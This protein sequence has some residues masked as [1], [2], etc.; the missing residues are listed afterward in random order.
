MNEISRF[1]ASLAHHAKQAGARTFP[2]MSTL[3]RVVFSTTGYSRISDVRLEGSDTFPG[4]EGVGHEEYNFVIP[5]LTGKRLALCA[6]G[7]DQCNGHNLYTWSYQPD[8]QKIVVGMFTNISPFSGE[9]HE[10]K[11]NLLINNRCLRTYIRRDLV[12]HDIPNWDAESFLK[13]APTIFH[14]EKRIALWDPIPKE[15]YH[16]IGKRFATTSKTW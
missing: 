8:G 12:R 10:Q 6:A 14:Y 15:V 5:Y 1:H 4:K 16:G 9:K 2:G 13:V 11:L 3:T 7:L